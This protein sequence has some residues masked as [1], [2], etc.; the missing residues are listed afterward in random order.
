M[1][2]NDRLMRALQ[3]ARDG[4]AVYPLAS[5]SK[6]PLKGTRGYKDAAT[7]V[8]TIKAGLSMSQGRTLASV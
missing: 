6:V 8:E 5:N 2:A 1:K 4:V 3:L 7:D